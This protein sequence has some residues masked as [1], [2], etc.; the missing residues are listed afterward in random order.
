MQPATRPE[1]AADP[2]P[3]LPLAEWRDT[4]RTVHLWTQIIGKIRLALSPP[5]NHWWHVALMV[6]PEGLGTGP[7]PYREEAFEIRLDLLRDFLEIRTSRGATRRLALRAEPVSRFYRRLMSALQSQGIEV[8]VNT[9]PQEI[10]DPIPFERDDRPGSYDHEFV[11]RWH[12]ILLS[13]AVVLQEFRSGFVGK[14]SPVHFFWGSFDLACTRF[15]G[16][17]APPRKGVISGPA[18]SHE[19]ISVGFW[20][21]GGLVDDAAFYAYAVPEP[22]GLQDQSIRPPGA[23]WNRELREF[24]LMYEGARRTG[25]P[26][27]ALLEFME[28][29]YEAAA[30]TANWDRASLEQASPPYRRAA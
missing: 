25:S 2:W 13:T 30:R 14:C 15:S 27:T 6:G 20:P 3:A 11:Q 4:C 29:A 17:P 23:A 8:E 5:L 19:V 24:V 7:I 9:R 22:P 28:S 1:I 10:A 16:R 26:R 21:G 18:Y 12:R